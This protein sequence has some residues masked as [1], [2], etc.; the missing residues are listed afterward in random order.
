MAWGSLVHTV[1]TLMPMMAAVSDC[2]YS[3][4]M[5]RLIS[6]R[7]T[8]ERRLRQRSTSRTKF[9]AGDPAAAYRLAQQGWRTANLRGSVEV[10]AEQVFGVLAVEGVG[11]LGLVRR[12]LEICLLVDFWK[13]PMNVMYCCG[14]W[15]RLPG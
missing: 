10:S 1:R 5:T 6:C 7:S 12:N 9:A 13:F 2:V 4:I 14:D 8:E 15:S 3:W 11:D